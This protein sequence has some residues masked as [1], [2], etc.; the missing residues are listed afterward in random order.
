MSK[1][2]EIVTNNEEL[3]VLNNRTE[4]I[5]KE[6]EKCPNCSYDK[7]CIE[8][9]FF[10]IKE[11]LGDFCYK[12]HGEVMK[13][14]GISIGRDERENEIIEIIKKELQCVSVGKTK[15]YY[16]DADKIISKIKEKNEK[17]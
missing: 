9:G 6:I 8:K 14:Q 1:K 10:K 12:H 15:I 17:N 4:E 5:K 11:L 3:I 2:Q 7:E 16:I 13:Q